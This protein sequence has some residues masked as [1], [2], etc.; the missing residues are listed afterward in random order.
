MALRPGWVA[1]LLGY[2]TVKTPA[3]T[4]VAQR[5]ILRFLGSG[6]SVADNPA[7]GET[8][9]TLNA[10][11]ITGAAYQ[12]LTIGGSTATLDADL[13]VNGKLTNSL[14]SGLLINV[15]DAADGEGGLIIVTNS[16]AD[17]AEPSFRL[18]GA[19][20]NVV[21][22]SFSGYWN[23]ANAAVNVFEWTFDGVRLVV[24]HLG[25]SPSLGA[26]LYA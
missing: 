2:F 20:T 14:P 23:T 26:P 12:T 22:P 11:A 1:D 6:F 9:V 24:V 19:A 15:V 3:G 10:G 17:A 18:N 25:C 8:E 4:A 21:A 13:G 16:V 5:S 7:T